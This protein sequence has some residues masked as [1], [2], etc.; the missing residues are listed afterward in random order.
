MACIACTPTSEATPPAAK[1]EPVES[2]VGDSSASDPVPPSDRVAVAP[3]VPT[4]ETLPSF[5]RR[6][7]F[8]WAWAERDQLR[9]ALLADEGLVVVARNG[10]T[11]DVVEDCHVAPKYA[12]EGAKTRALTTTLEST[13]ELW[14]NLPSRAA[15]DVS[16][17]RVEFQQGGVFVPDVPL[18]PDGTLR[19][20]VGDLTPTG[21]CDT[22]THVVVEVMVGAA[23][24]ER[25]DDART[26]VEIGRRGGCGGSSSVRARFKQGCLEPY[27]VAL[28]PLDP[29]AVYSGVCVSPSAWTGLACDEPDPERCDAGSTRLECSGERVALEH[30]PP[31]RLD[32]LELP[33]TDEDVGFELV[34]DGPSGR[35]TEVC[36]VEPDEGE[37]AADLLAASLPVSREPTQRFAVRACPPERVEP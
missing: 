25:L 20:E 4:C 14:A 31:T 8:D 7:T 2:C 27:A 16:P 36:G 32:P 23:E 26:L 37:R 10:C 1:P 12:Y 3:P 15:S 35:I 29:H 18:E 19:F 34:V 11:V 17:V 9:D 30:F 5:Q 22:A 6:L 28:V 13:H 24:L 21:R 33:C